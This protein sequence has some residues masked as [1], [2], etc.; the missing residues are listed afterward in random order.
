MAI[1]RTAFTCNEAKGT[2]EGGAIFHVSPIVVEEEAEDGAST[3]TG[4]GTFQGDS[5]I[6]SDSVFRANVGYRSNNIKATQVRFLSCSAGRYAEESQTHFH[7]DDQ[8]DQRGACPH[9][10][11]DGPEAGLTLALPLT[12]CTFKLCAPGKYATKNSVGGGGGFYTCAQCPKGQT[13][14]RGATA[15]TACGARTYT[16]VEGLAHCRWCSDGSRVNGDHTACVRCYEGTHAVYANAAAADPDP[17]PDPDQSQSPSSGSGEEEAATA[18]DAGTDAGNGNRYN[19]RRAVL[20]LLFGAND[21][22]PVNNNLS[23][24]NQYFI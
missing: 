12:N 17:D 18:A 2:G 4:T 16:D 13:S 3:G 8:L 22:L 5:L 20:S 9:P 15:C 7:A 21:E 19:I 10:C 6:L 14:A 1:L 23:L 24:Q 11:Q